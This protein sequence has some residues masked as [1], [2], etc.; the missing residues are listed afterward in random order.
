MWTGTLCWCIRP[1]HSP[2]TCYS[3]VYSHLLGIYSMH[4]SL[5]PVAVSDNICWKMVLT[6]RMRSTLSQ[7]VQSDWYWNV[8]DVY[9]NIPWVVGTS[10]SSYC[11]PILWY[12]IG[13]ELESMWAT[14]YE[15]FGILSSI[16]DPYCPFYDSTY[17]FDYC[18]YPLMT[19]VWYQPLMA[20]LALGRMVS[21]ISIGH[22]SYNEFPSDYLSKPSFSL[23]YIQH[24]SLCEHHNETGF[25]NDLWLT[26]QQPT[27]EW[28]LCH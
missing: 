20:V 15:W 25:V 1:P 4:I 6:T 5:L 23:C 16:S 14:N 7:T 24:H 27:S 18:Y 12:F 9:C 10:Y 11:Q 21:F 2:F 19:I 13:Y 17:L 26:Y 3:R 8:L 22:S 28:S